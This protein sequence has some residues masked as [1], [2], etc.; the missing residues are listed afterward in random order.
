MAKGAGQSV[1]MSVVAAG[2]GAV[3][4]HAGFEMLLK[5]DKTLLI[6]E[7]N[8]TRTV[9]AVLLV[10]IGI[11][12]FSATGKLLALA[13]EEAIFP[14][15]V[16]PEELWEEISPALQHRLHYAVSKDYSKVVVKGNDLY[17]VMNI[18]EQKH[19]RLVGKEGGVVQ[20]SKSM[21]KYISKIPVEKIKPAVAP[22]PVRSLQPESFWTPQPT[23]SSA[24]NY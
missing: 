3:I 12:L 7:T 10:G 17:E 14:E 18:E 2:I 1:V 21:S 24:Q 6:G 19:I 13:V 4:T 22:T 15:S 8:D 20:M 16:T 23:F 9:A 5:Q 11:L